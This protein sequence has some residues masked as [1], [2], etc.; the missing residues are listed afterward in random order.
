MRSVHDSSGDHDWYYLRHPPLDRKR[1]HPSLGLVLEFL[2]TGG[3]Q[4]KPSPEAP[5]GAATA[6]RGAAEKGPWGGHTPGVMASETSWL[7]GMGTWMRVPE[8]KCGIRSPA[9]FIP[10]MPERTPSCTQ[11]ENM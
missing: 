8:L 10:L 7:D 5:G 9:R 6:P 4:G 3:P 2:D 1:R 11:S